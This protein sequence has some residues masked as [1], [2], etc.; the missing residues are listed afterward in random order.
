MINPT[1]RLKHQSQWN[2]WRRDIRIIRESIKIREFQSFASQMTSHNCWNRFDKIYTTIC[3]FTKVEN[4][5]VKMKQCNLMFSRFAVTRIVYTSG[6]VSR[7][8]SK[9]CL[10]SL[11]FHW[12]FGARFCFGFT[13]QLGQRLRLFWKIKISMPPRVVFL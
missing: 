13:C 3:I 12:S 4:V 9:H 11:S 8:C 7:Q 6:C 1:M 2:I 5:V 10:P